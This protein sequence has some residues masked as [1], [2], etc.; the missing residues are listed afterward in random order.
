MN[1]LVLELQSDALNPGVDV[2][3]LLRRALVVSKKLDLADVVEWLECELNGYNNGQ[4]IPDYRKFHGTLK[5]RNPYHGWQPVMF[6][7]TKLAN[8]LSEK[9][10]PQPLAELEH[11]LKTG[12]DGQII[13]QFQGEHLEIIHRMTGHT[14][15][16]ALFLSKAS[17]SRAVEAVRTH[18]LEWA[19]ELEKR[20][21]L[22]AGMTFSREEKQAA[23]QVSYSTVNH[24]GSM[25]NSQL[26]QHSAGTQTQINSGA[27]KQITFFLDTVDNKKAALKLPEPLAQELEAEIATLRAQVQSPKPKVHIL[28]ES[29]RSLKSIFENA[30]G[31]VAGTLLLQQLVPMM[32]LI[33]GIAS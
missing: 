11:M 9:A 3:A 12:G 16:A 1:G 4:D 14:L 27:L 32:A 2:I 28:A 17:L 21:V 22:G 7:D 20:G 23:S 13:F 19:L 10:T 31:N 15:E 24:I 25:T 8:I 26:Q 33:A 29:F 5:M 30:A 6:A 18:V